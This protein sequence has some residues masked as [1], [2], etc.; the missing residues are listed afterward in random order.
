MYA[1]P[2]RTP[3]RVP[4]VAVDSICVLLLVFMAPFVSGIALNTRYFRGRLWKRE[5]YL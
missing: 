2:L 3:F 1:V 4:Y 5:R